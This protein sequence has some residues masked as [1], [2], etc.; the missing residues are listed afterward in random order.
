MCVKVISRHL[1]N[2]SSS[3]GDVVCG[4]EKLV[5]SISFPA[6]KL[7]TSVIFKTLY[8]FDIV[9]G[10]STEPDDPTEKAVWLKRD[11]D[12]QRVIVTS[13][14]R[15]YV[16]LIL[17]CTNSCEMY[18]KVCSLFEGEDDLQVQ[19]LL[20]EF[21][22]FKYKK[23]Q[24]MTDFIGAMD[25]LVYKLKSLKQTMSDEMV[26]SRLLLALPDYLTN[27]QFPMMW[28][29][30]TAADRTL[31][32]LKLRLLKEE[33]R[34]KNRKPEIPVAFQTTSNQK[35]FKKTGA[36]GDGAQ[37][38]TATVKCH[39]CSG[40]GHYA[41]ECPSKKPCRH[42]KK[43]NHTEEKCFFRP[44]PEEGKETQNKTSA[45]KVS[46]LTFADKSERSTQ[47][48]FVVDSGCSRHMIK[49]ISACSKILR[50]IRTL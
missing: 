29:S 30:V 7:Q 4:I 8:A 9:N 10:T 47:D 48:S 28:D 38:R 6:W 27:A 17:N 33:T 39:N 44:K 5:N 24:T 19:E 25:V 13:I 41:R 16:N 45:E 49:K 26:M 40:F 34:F 15:K 46:L 31:D 12:A 18:K 32:K 23:D 22:T 2:M 50:K 36:V 21:H 1:V 43:N 3:T 20:E 14:D 37:S 35:D 42:C 11:A